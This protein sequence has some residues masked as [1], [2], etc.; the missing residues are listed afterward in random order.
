M[1]CIC[2]ASAVHI[3]DTLNLAAEQ[4]GKNEYL[5]GKCRL[6]YSLNEKNLTDV[7]IDQIFL[8]RKNF[9]LCDYDCGMC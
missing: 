3:V 8:K 7:H 1:L 5:N 6:R 4:L 2:F 9:A